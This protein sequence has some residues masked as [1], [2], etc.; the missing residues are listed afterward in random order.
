MVR[1]YL[2]IVPGLRLSG[3]LSGMGPESLDLGTSVSAK[4]VREDP[5]AGCSSKL[6][7]FIICKRCT[8]SSDNPKHKRSGAGKRPKTKE[9]QNVAFRRTWIQ[10]YLRRLEN[11]D[12]TRTLTTHLS[13]WEKT[14]PKKCVRALAVWLGTACLCTKTKCLRALLTKCLRALLA[15]CVS[16][17]P[18]TS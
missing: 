2:K 8:P 7:F 4:C 15:K 13:P 5:I 3:S 10:S 12:A 6:G 11:R 17:L 14:K 16:V 1:N 9:I 18:K